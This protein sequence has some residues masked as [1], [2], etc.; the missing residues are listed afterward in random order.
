[1]KK[2]DRANTDRVS[3]G[4]GDG[5]VLN[6]NSGAGCTTLTVLTTSRQRTL[7]R[8]I[9]RYMNCILMVSIWAQNWCLVTGGFPLCCAS[10]ADGISLS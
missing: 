1:M 5:H 7:K 9:L 10:A 3:L 6:L 8:Q 4:G 2:G